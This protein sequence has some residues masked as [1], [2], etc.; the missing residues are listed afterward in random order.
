MYIKQEL[1]SNTASKYIVEAVNFF[2][3]SHILFSKSKIL[4]S[5]AQYKEIYYFSIHFTSL[6]MAFC[7]NK[8]SFRSNISRINNGPQ[9]YNCQY[10]DYSTNNTSHMKYHNVTHTGEQPYQC[11]ICHQKFSLKC[12]LQRHLQHHSNLNS[13]YCCNICSIAFRSKSSLTKH[14]NM[15]HSF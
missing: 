10:C 3:M 14:N 5:F 11:L 2:C 9:R 15:K 13:A 4:F 7:M 8:V 1:K 12:N 6:G